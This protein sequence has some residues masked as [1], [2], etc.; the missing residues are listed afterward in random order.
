[1]GP[2]IQLKPF[3]AAGWIVNAV[4]RKKYRTQLV[5]FRIRVKG[6]K[7]EMRSMR[8]RAGVFDV[9]IQMAIQ[10]ATALKDQN[11]ERAVLSGWTIERGSSI[12]KNF[13]SEV[14]GP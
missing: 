7:C 12:L 8:Q 1:M 4:F 14:T 6:F 2:A 5:R 9:L 11:E 10:M 3:R 13:C